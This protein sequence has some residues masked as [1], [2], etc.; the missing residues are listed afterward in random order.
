MM[1]LVKKRKEKS[2]N[3]KPLHY[4]F[5]ADNKDAFRKYK[6]VEILIEMLKEYKSVVVAKTLTHAIS[7]NGKSNS[8]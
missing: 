8:C 2:N 5:T 4:S 3:N 6:G 7:G 1:R